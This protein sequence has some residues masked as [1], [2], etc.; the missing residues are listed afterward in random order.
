MSSTFIID[1]P[2]L[3]LDIWGTMISKK[4]KKKMGYEL[5]FGTLNGI[6]QNKKLIIEYVPENLKNPFIMS[7]IKL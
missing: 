5:I 3:G 2:L 6:F 7:K 1:P 4:L